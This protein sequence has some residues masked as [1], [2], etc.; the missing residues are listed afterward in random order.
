M[1]PT[2]EKCREAPEFSGTFLGLLWELK[3]ERGKS[4]NVR[5]G[6]GK[7]AVLSLPLNVHKRTHFSKE[8]I[9]E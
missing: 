5:G 2:M 9:Y 3:M 6:I 4:K 7:E 8:T 1:S